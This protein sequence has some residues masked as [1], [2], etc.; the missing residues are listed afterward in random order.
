MKLKYGILLLIG[1]ILA[2]Y[3]VYRIFFIREK[4]VAVTVT[5]GQL[6][7]LIY[8]TGKV[9]A[10]AN[11]ILRCESGGN[12]TFLGAQEGSW[13]RKGTLLLR[14]DKSEIELKINQAENEIIA[15][16]IDLRDKKNNIE[17]LSD[18]L[19]VHSITQ[20]EYDSAKRDYDLAQIVLERRKIILSQE[21]ENLSK[22][23]ITAPFDCVVYSVSVNIGDYLP[24]NT[25]CFRILDPGSIMVEAQVDEQDLAKVTT[26][27][28]SLVAFDAY[29][30]KKFD[31]VVF[32][33]VPQTD[34][35]TKTSKVFLKLSAQPAKLNIGMTAT[36]NIVA[37]KKENVLIIPKTAVI[38]KNNKKFVFQIT[39]GRLHEVEVTIGIM[40]GNYVEL[41]SGVDQNSQVVLEPNATN[42]ENQKVA[43]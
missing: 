19:Q 34:E 18:L 26:D 4:V 27:Q 5:R 10:D 14:S 24:P 3:I 8:A 29:P 42:K 36:V 33:I 37:G 39:D 11:A 43:L 16:E 12:I 13:V 30:G 17:K 2:G 28:H 22:R 41:L 15:A 20:K 6:V 1:I 40:E 23:T 9:S 7:S 25:E 35:A 38:N 21:K 31:A 32:R